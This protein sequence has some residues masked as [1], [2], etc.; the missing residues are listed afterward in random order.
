MSPAELLPAERY[1]QLRK[2]GL[3]VPV[4]VDQV[5]R[6]RDV[7]EGAGGRPLEGSKPYPARSAEHPRRWF[8]CR[9]RSDPRSSGT[10]SRTIFSFLLRARATVKACSQVTLGARITSFPVTK[11]VSDVVGEICPHP[12]PATF[13]RKSPVN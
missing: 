2:M 1:H 9:C 12:A 6:E 3:I 4:L 8:R 13:S 11:A 7:V 5:A 10:V